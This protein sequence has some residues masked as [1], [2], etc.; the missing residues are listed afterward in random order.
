MNLNCPVRYVF[1][2]IPGTNFCALP[3]FVSKASLINLQ[4]HSS[5]PPPFS[6]F[7]DHK[8]DQQRQNQRDSAQAAKASGELTKA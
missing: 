7:A 4:T 1:D 3:L 2:F 6:K 8:T 5:G